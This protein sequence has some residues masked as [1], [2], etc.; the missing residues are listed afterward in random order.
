MAMLLIWN[1]LTEPQNLATDSSKTRRS[2]A[3]KQTPKST[4][5]I[6]VED[7]DTSLQDATADQLEELLTRINEWDKESVLAVR[8]S[9]NKDRVRVADQMLK[10]P[11]SDRQRTLAIESK[12]SALSSLY[13]IEFVSG[14]DLPEYGTSL[15]EFAELN[16]GS[17]DAELALKC[18][19]ELFKV[20]AFD[21][22]RNQKPGDIELIADRMS[23]LLERYPDKEFVL[24]TI[25]LVIQAL[26]GYDSDY[27]L[28]LMNETIARADES[29][30]L[31]DEQFIQSLTDRA[32]IHESDYQNLF[33]NR[34][35]Y[36]ESSRQKLLDAT[37]ALATDPECGPLVL[38][39]IEHVLNS[40]EQDKQYDECR[41]IF[42]A[43]LDSANNRKI[44]PTRLAAKQLAEHGLSRINLIG[45]K[46][47]FNGNLISGEALEKAEF[48]NKIVV[49]IFWSAKERESFE[50]LRKFHSEYLVRRGPRVP[51]LAVCTDEQFDEDFNLQI[52]NIHEFQVVTD[53]VGDPVENW[54]GD[55]YPADLVPNTLIVNRIGEVEVINVPM[56]E[57]ATTIELL[58]MRQDDELQDD[59]NATNSGRSLEDL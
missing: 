18:N 5:P 42:Q 54:I 38:K 35:I 2:T 50:Q 8:M 57:L 17:E 30:S 14:L 21:S 1:R 52:K 10:L 59:G 37:L 44:E 39:R 4:I 33:E 13:G 31:F 34:W 22:V 26:Y 29:N 45:K 41:G 23:E 7:L 6:K 40:L 12:L 32:K 55:Q 43:I 51:V 11:M 20:A 58:A 24:S 16:K 36:G 27:G 25:D 56:D 47:E 53:R 19:L 28:E 46:L 15:R 49:V 48:E 3:A 9:Q